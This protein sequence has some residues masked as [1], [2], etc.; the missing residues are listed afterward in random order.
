MS[1]TAL[2]NTAYNLTLD[3]LVSIDANDI[4]IN[5]QTVDLSSYLPYTGA[6]KLVDLGSNAISS[7][8]T[9]ISNFNLT[10]K[11]YVD[12]AVTGILTLNNTYTGTNQFNNNVSTGLGYTTDLNGIIQTKL[13]SLGFSSASFTTSGI[14]GTYTPPLGTITNPSGTTYQI[15]QTAQ[16]R[17]VMAIS[18]FAPS[19]LTTYVFQIN[20]KCT[21]GT[22]ILSVEQDNILRSPQ[23]YQLSTS[24]NT[25]LGSFYYDGNPSTI[26]FKIYAGVASWNAQWDSFTLS[27]YSAAINNPL[28]LN[29]QITGTAVAGLGLNSLKQIVSTAVPAN[30]SAVSVGSVPYESSSDVFSNSIMTQGLTDFGY[31]G[32]SF[33]ASTGIGS[34]TF[35]SPTYTANSSASFQGIITLSALPATALNLPCTATF[36]ALSFPFFAVSPYP[37]F[38]L[39]NGSTVVYT[40]A[41]GASGTISMPFTPTSTTLFITIYFKAPPTPQT[42]GILTWTN[43]T[44]TTPTMITTGNNT[45]TGNASVGGT[46]TTGG[47]ISMA[48]GIFRKNSAGAPNS[49]ITMNGGD[50][51][52]SPFMEFVYGSLRRGYIGNATASTLQLA[53]ENNCDFN[54]L[55]GGS[56]RMIV[57]NNGLIGF[58]RDPSYAVDINGAMRVLN[59]LNA[60]DSKTVYGPNA[61]WSA[62]LTVGSGTDA[63]GPS[64][65]QILSTNGNLHIDAGNSND[66][67]YG[68][69]PSS[70]GTPNTHQFYGTSVNFP[71]G[72]PQNG[73]ASFGA[74]VAVFDGNTLKKSQCVQKLVYFNNNVAWGGGVNMTYAFYL[75]NTACSVQFWGKNSGYYSGAGM[76]QTMIRVYSQ[77]QGTYQYYPINAF[78]NVGYNHFTVPLNYAANFGVTGWYDIYVYST[79][80]WITDGNDQ[81]T[82]GVSISP[83]NGF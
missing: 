28:T 3:G 44:I 82:I 60:N 63:S 21:V 17:S 45:I 14:T 47:N 65:A 30:F 72:L 29:N 79:S 1:L 50:G 27:T 4:S 48:T 51:S 33:T 34:I 24:F 67:Y 68:Y 25:I 49:W 40:S 16:G 75:Y 7:S 71:S 39:T 74:Q 19:V 18:G 53:A 35:A 15:T 42:A 55:T 69:Y 2:N 23:Y 9:A 43:F 46:L 31:T 61:T 70:R 81:L 41:T 54:L 77:V 58:G 36:T 80:G 22:A 59:G 38:T 52:N 56:T 62:F 8:Y 78:V 66:I 5:G 83:A 73:N 32:A 57:K 12:S 6:S 26:I 76:M 20:I 37:Y 10:N 11:S 64:T 13:N